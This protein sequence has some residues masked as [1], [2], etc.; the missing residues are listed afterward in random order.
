MR[1]NKS[2]VSNE[3]KVVTRYNRAPLYFQKDLLPV[4]EIQESPLDPN[5][6]GNEDDIVP[7][8]SGESGKAAEE[9]F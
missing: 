6:P 4:E 5:H 8:F 2:F 3:L 1:D 9:V 7:S